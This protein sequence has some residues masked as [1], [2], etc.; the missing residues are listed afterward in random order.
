MARNLSAKPAGRRFWAD[1]LGHGQTAFSH[2][3]TRAWR[4]I[5]HAQSLFK[6]V[7]NEKRTFAGPNAN[8]TATKIGLQKCRAILLMA[9]DCKMWVRIPWAAEPAAAKPARPK[10]GR[11]QSNPRVDP[12]WLG[13]R[14]FGVAPTSL[15]PANRKNHGQRPHQK[16][17]SDTAEKK[18]RNKAG[19]S[20]VFFKTR[21]SVFL[22]FS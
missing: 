1:R 19:K 22:S 16:R 3:R 4:F 9:R 11:P 5:N 20:L 7:R 12:W 13:A 14:S 17:D 21:K 8:P 18:R 6:N 2:H 15:R 10:I